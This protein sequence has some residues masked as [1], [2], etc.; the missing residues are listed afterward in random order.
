[1]DGRVTPPQPTRRSTSRRSS[2][3]SSNPG[4]ILFLPIG[5]LH[6]VEGMEISVTISFTNFVFHNDFSSFYTTYHQV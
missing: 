4:E 6:Y 2:S 1:M 5:C 3:A